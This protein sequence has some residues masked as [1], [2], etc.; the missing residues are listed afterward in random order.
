MISR[1]LT[2]LVV[3]ACVALA[4]CSDTLT[5]PSI[6]APYSQ[7]DLRL[8]SGTEAAKSASVTVNYT[9][10]IYDPTQPDGKGLIFDTSIGGTPLTFTLGAGQVI[11]GFDRGVTG[12]KIGGARRIVIPPSLGYGATRNNSIPPYSTLIFEIDLLD[13]VVPST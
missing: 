4:A 6:G 5:G 3:A 12:M 11:Q 13:V 8:G 1:C 9:G 2:I 10:W 7:L